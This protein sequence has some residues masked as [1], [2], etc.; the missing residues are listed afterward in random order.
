MKNSKRSKD[1]FKP[2]EYGLL[3]NLIGHRFDSE[4]EAMDDL[5]TKME[6]QDQL[7]STLMADKEEEE[8]R[9]FQ[10]IA[11]KMLINRSARVIQRAWRAFRERK[12]K[13]RGKKGI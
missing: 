1:F 2:Q 7:Y 11:Y 10:E 3:K 6:E 8:E 13:R 5:E 12:H 9:L 4:K